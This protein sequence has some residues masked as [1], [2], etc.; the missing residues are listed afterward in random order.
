GF[1]LAGAAS[2]PTP[3]NHSPTLLADPAGA[4]IGPVNNVSD[5]AEQ[6]RV[7]RWL[8]RDWRPTRLA[9]V[10]NRIPGGRPRRVFRRARWWPSRSPDAAPAVSAPPSWPCRSMAAIATWSRCWATTPAG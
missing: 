6:G 10:V 9:R 5:P 3:N 2:S 4:T 1:D 7:M 8:Y